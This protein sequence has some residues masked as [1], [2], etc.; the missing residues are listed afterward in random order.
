MIGQTISHYRIDAELG[1][2]GMGVVYRAQ[3][4]RLGRAVALKFLP[5]T[6]GRDAAAMERLRREAR[7]ASALSHPNICIIHDIG[8]DA[9]GRA[10]LVL[11]LLE[12]ETLQARLRRGALATG[13]VLELGIETAA[14]LEAAH[15]KGI[16][17]RDLKPANIFLTREG[18]AKVLDFGLAK[19]L[20]SHAAAAGGE[21][22]PTA[23]GVGASELTQAGAALGTVAYMSPE[24]ARGQAVDGR[25]DIFS[26]GVVLYEAASGH[27][28]FPGATSAV[29]FDGI[30]N[31]APEL[32]AVGSAE[33]SAL[34][35]KALEK[36][37]GMR[38]QSAAELRTDLKRLKRDSE[39]GLR[40]A[41]SAAARPAA[42]K[43]SRWFGV[44]ALAAAVMLGGGLW[45]GFGRTP[46]LKAKDTVVLA[47]F[48][49]ATG[50]AMFN[51]ALRQG[52][53]SQLA[54]TPYLNLV[55]DDRMA[56][57]EKLMTLA[58][59]T[60]IVGPVARQLCQ[61]TNS[62]AT[63]EG[64]IAQV[65][66]Q[67]SLV[68]NANNCA[69]GD[70]MATVSETA[71]SKDQVLHAL[72][73]AADGLRDKLGES[74]AS[75]REFHAPIEQVTTPSLEALQDYTLGRQAMALG[76][77]AAAADQ[78][79]R[80]VAVDSNFAM[81]YAS[82]STAETDMRPIQQEA[83]IANI[84]RAYG[85]R[86][87]VS[88]RER[89]YITARY[90]D[91]AAED[92]LQT[93]HDYQAWERTYPNDPLPFGNECAVAS[94][95][96]P[97]NV[98]DPGCNLAFKLDPNNVVY[99]ANW[100]IDLA[101]AGRRAESEAVFADGLKRWPD[102]LNLHRT[103]FDAATQ[104]QD[105]TSLASE[106]AWLGARGN[107]GMLRNYSAAGARN[108]G[109]LGRQAAFLQ[110]NEAAAAG[111]PSAAAGDE[112]NIGLGKVWYGQHS[113]AEAAADRALK[114][115][116]DHGSLTS[117]ALIYAAAGDVV[118]ANAT[119]AELDRSVGR[120]SFYR[121]I[122]MAEIRGAVALAQHQPAQ[123]IAALVS[124]EPYE[125]G[126]LA[127]GLPAYLRGLALM[128]EG[129]GTAAV[130]EFQK[131][132]ALPTVTEFPVLAR[133]GQ[134]RAQV[135]AGDTAGARATYRGLMEQ[136][137]NADAGVPV[138]EA[139]RAEYAKLR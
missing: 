53:A 90:D 7:A 117:A 6:L 30:L 131:V 100:A 20:P 45:Y 101:L 108:A 8:E 73:A 105:A 14:A 25:S 21:D 84:T 85:L 121:I 44:A 38:Y 81:A 104:F 102:N 62:A 92:E 80:A 29:V 17:H 98:I 77:F 32:S 114:I 74:L 125:A 2:G 78:F 86:D 130:G 138:I 72:G 10:F 129:Q 33:L 71:S 42:R 46:M 12:G 122:G 61:R 97:P 127:I 119:M 68:L 124:V 95:L 5:A 69:T 66:D 56:E 83:A 47:D 52:L 26:L 28:A 139:A 57:A 41:S 24:Q 64:S 126:D 63:I 22:A 18:H 51:A 36:D 113:E 35:G 116:R 9:E 23:A 111:N 58:P 54:Q 60:A 11:E 16:V 118:K 109:E 37:P 79:Q 110:Q 91:T 19:L 76:D 50:D 75:M 112:L 136:W 120:Q 93:E 55:S 137:K 134:A 82:L 40:S 123:A 106:T 1:S 89:L 43:R 87:R 15:A 99:V 65:G 31:R 135:M 67:Y 115:S 59:N 4:L 96:D 70:L 133:L 103:H 94:H 3:D 132:V 48:N 128:Q 39:S 13:E 34:L 27:G 88:E 107:G 49:N